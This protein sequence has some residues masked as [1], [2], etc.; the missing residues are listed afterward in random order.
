MISYTLD[1]Y[2]NSLVLTTALTILNFS[3]LHIIQSAVCCTPPQVLASPNEPHLSASLS[4]TRSIQEI[5]H[6]LEALGVR[7]SLLICV[8][9]CALPYVESNCNGNQNQMFLECRTSVPQ[10][11]ENSDYAQDLG[12]RY[13]K[14]KNTSD[15][16]VYLS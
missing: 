8:W 13:A 11:I 16:I 1:T 7:H 14:T 9:R 4:L 6:R 3:H 10:A 5:Y 15:D 12:E 2:V